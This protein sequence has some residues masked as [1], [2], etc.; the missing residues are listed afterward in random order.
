MRGIRLGKK[1][2]DDS[3][4]YL[5]ASKPLQAT[6]GFQLSGRGKRVTLRALALVFAIGAA[7]WTLYGVVLHSA[8]FP[9]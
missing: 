9:D 6:G 7:G 5:R 8:P 1:R 2:L 4:A 3:S